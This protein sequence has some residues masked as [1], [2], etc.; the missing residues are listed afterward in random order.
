MSI[1]RATLKGTLVIGAIQGL[2]GGLGFAVVGIDAAAFWGVVM[3]VASI[4]PGIGPAR[5]RAFVDHCV[6]WAP[7]LGLDPVR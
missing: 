4:I 1:S 2:L 6:A 3:A 5:V 7:R